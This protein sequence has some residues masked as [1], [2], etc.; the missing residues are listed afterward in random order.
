MKQL[1]TTTSIFKKRLQSLDQAQASGSQAGVKN[2]NSINFPTQKRA[3]N[4]RDGPKF[5]LLPGK[6]TQLLSNKTKCKNIS[7]PGW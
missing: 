4:A 1:S 3:L 7:S 2:S 5:L 6:G